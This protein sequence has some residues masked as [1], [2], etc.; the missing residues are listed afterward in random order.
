MQALVST[1]ISWPLNGAHLNMVHGGKSLMLLN[2]AHLNKVHGGKSLMLLNGAQLN[3][4]HGGKR[5]MLSRSK[6][7]KFCHKQHESIVR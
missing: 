5:S 1:R 3:K 6:L 4:V 2:G 7:D